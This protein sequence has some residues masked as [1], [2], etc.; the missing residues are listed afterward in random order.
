MYVETRED[1]KCIE[2]YNAAFLFD[3][4]GNFG[5]KD[6]RVAMQWIKDNIEAFGGDPELITA[7]GESSGAASVGYHMMST[8][9]KNL[10]KRSIFESG[11]PDSH[12]SFMSVEQAKQRSRAFFQNVNCPDDGEILKCL[13][14]LDSKAIL[15]HEW[16]DTEFLV[17]PWV[18]TVDGDFLTDTPHNLLKAGKFVLKDSL[19]GINKDE[20]TFWILYSV[21]GLSKDETSLLTHAQYRAGVD[22]IDWD[23]SNGTRER[24]KEMYSPLNKSDMAGNRYV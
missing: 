2:Q 1:V 9:S 14:K 21:N 4:S 10:F 3:F 11:S 23:L 16:V 13:R 24:V 8:D 6:Q 18:P 17:F 7:F 20:G 12:W 19:L 22:I 15:T 5:L